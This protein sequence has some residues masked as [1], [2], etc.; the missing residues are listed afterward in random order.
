MIPAKFDPDSSAPA[1]RH[2]TTF[3]SIPKNNCSSRHPNAE[4]PNPSTRLPADVAF[5][6]L[7]PIAAEPP[8]TVAYPDRLIGDL[9]FD[10]T[11]WRIMVFEPFARLG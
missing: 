10:A 7:S 8:R 2:A 11:L 5:T 6:K 4:R 3:S 9:G 1:G